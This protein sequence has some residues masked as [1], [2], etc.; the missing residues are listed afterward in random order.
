MKFTSEDLMKAMGLQVGDYVRIKTKELEK[1]TF[2]VD[3]EDGLMLVYEGYEYP[4][5]YLVDHEYEIL[6]RPKRVG[7]LQCVE[8]E[9]A[10]CP[11]RTIRCDK[12]DDIGNSLYYILENVLVG[13]DF[14]Q[15]IYDLLKARLDKEVEE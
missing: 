3:D 10:K 5:V 11:L 12:N 8:Y 1:Y 15:E 6:P 9:C 13:A 14:D 7:D 2:L 4:I